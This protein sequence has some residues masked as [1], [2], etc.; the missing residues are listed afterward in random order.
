MGF[1]MPS[2]PLDRN[3]TTHCCIGS[4][5][6]DASEY[7]MHFYAVIVAV[8]N[9]SGT[10]SDPLYIWS[11][12]SKIVHLSALV[13][14]LIFVTYLLLTTQSVQ[15]AAVMSWFLLWGV[16]NSYFEARLDLLPPTVRGN[17]SPTNNKMPMNMIRGNIPLST[18][19]VASIHPCPSFQHASYQEWGS[20][21]WTI[22]THWEK[23][24]TQKIL[25]R[26]S[27]IGQNLNYLMIQWWFRADSSLPK[28]L[29]PN[30]G[31]GWPWYICCFEKGR[32]GP[33]TRQS[34]VWWAMENW[35]TWA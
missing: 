3:G 12:K 15:T 34:S 31:H 5:S 24:H 22:L 8:G 14:L 13:I 35:W 21:V 30:L 29:I 1:R 16:Y 10:G 17:P 9:Y 27:N 18:G 20:R 23:H 6:R 25:E 11:V 7:C 19:Q 32:N 28:I 4:Q 26:I 2:L 33:F